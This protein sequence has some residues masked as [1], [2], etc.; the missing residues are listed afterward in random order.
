MSPAPLT[1]LGL[2]EAVGNAQAVGGHRLPVDHPQQGELGGQR[3]HDHGQVS[4]SNLRA[5]REKRDRKI[6]DT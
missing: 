1:E 2:D 5:E 6:S 3:V 4:F